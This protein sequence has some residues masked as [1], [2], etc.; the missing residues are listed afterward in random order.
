M[1][2]MINLNTTDETHFMLWDIGAKSINGKFLCTINTKVSER[3]F[4][5]STAKTR[6]PIRRL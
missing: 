2:H 3:N 1:P 4:G 6:A 5:D